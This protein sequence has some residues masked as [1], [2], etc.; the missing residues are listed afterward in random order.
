MQYRADPVPREPKKNFW[1]AKA[2]TSAS[3]HPGH[4]DLLPLSC[5]HWS[6]TVQLAILYHPQ[7]PP[8]S[9]AP[10]HFQPTQHSPTPSRVYAPSTPPCRPPNP[11]LSCD[12]ALFLPTSSSSSLS[13][14]KI[15]LK[16]GPTRLHPHVH[17]AEPRCTGLCYPVCFLTSPAPHNQKSTAA[18]RWGWPVPHAVQ[19][20]QLP[21]ALLIQ[22]GSFPEQRLWDGA[23]SCPEQRLWD[24]VGATSSR[25]PSPS[26][27]AG[28][29]TSPHQGRGQ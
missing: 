15:G 8:L 29:S 2:G 26:Q 18:L 11:V 24:D 6:L 17:S 23:G 9:P 21:L 3:T 5:F 27:A 7:P 13:R 28:P 10:S 25:N 20:F 19:P 12:P 1:W 14:E 4:V 22:A 16:G